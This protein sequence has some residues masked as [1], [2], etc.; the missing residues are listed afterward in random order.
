VAARVDEL[1]GYLDKSKIPEL[2]GR[3]FLQHISYSLVASPAEVL[4]TL[5]LGK[6]IREKIDTLLHLCFDSKATTP[7]L[8]IAAVEAVKP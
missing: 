6:R 3:F 2:S 7:S 4:K 1:R 8:K 5:K